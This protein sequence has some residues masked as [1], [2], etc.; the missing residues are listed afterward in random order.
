MR[1][2]NQEDFTLTPFQLF[3]AAFTIGSFGGM[4]R[5]LNSNEKITYRTMAA[6]FLKSGIASLTIALLLHSYYG[7][8]NPFFLLG[9]GAL[10]GI[11]AIDLV[12]IAAVVMSKVTPDIGQHGSTAKKKGSPDDYA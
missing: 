10:A 2:T 1:A 3:S 8:T 6:A 9:V 4:A 11:G 12:D 7:T 5:L